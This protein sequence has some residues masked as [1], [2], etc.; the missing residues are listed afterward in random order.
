MNF[1]LNFTISPQKEKALFAF[2]SNECDCTIL[3]GYGVD[4][5]FSVDICEEPSL[6]LY[7]IVPQIFANVVRIESVCDQELSAN[8]SIYP[9]DENGC[10][11]PLIRYERFEGL[12]RF[13]AGVSAMDGQG[14]TTIKAI[15]KKIKQWITTNATS[16]YREGTPF[17]GI[18]IYELI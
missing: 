13:Y 14:K 10:N 6:L 7:V 4:K 17:C 12:Y 2:L 15:L 8:F 11:F 16:H 3:K 5:N 9:F 18:T 1:Q